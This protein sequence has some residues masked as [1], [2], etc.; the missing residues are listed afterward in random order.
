M[1]LQS[2]MLDKSVVSGSRIASSI[3]SRKVSAACQA[4]LRVL[5]R[6]GCLRAAAILA[7]VRLEGSLGRPQLFAASQ[8]LPSWPRCSW[9][10]DS[11]GRL[12]WILQQLPSLLCQMGATKGRQSMSSCHPSPG[13]VA[14]RGCCHCLSPLQPWPQPRSGL[15][16]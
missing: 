2:S 9:W 8:K 4:E 5:Q 7:Q 13:K 12:Q 6:E 3:S 1:H 11:S 16:P 10:E 14:V 15:V